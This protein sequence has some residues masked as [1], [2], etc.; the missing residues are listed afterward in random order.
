M[1]VDPDTPEVVGLKEAGRRFSVSSKHL[2]REIEAGRLPGKKV[3]PQFRVRLE[4]VRAWFD[5]LPDA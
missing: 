3:G 1:T 5:A 4:D 2:R